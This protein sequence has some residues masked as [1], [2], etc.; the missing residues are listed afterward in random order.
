[1]GTPYAK[2]Y[3]IA[4][5]RGGSSHYFLADISSELSWLAMVEIAE[6][7]PGAVKL[8]IPCN[9]EERLTVTLSE[10]RQL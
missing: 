9:D 5:C 1:M 8:W 10:R 2:S 4:L 6:D 3:T 7:G